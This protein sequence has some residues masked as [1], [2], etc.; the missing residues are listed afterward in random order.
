MPTAAPHLCTAHGCTAIV[1]AGR[2]R[3]EKHT[4]QR[5]A[6]A[7]VSR[8]ARPETAQAARIRSSGQWKQVSATLRAQNPLC[9]V[10]GGLAEHMHHI[11]PLIEAPELAYAPANLAPLC[12]GCHA[13][14]EAMTTAGRREE[15]AVMLK[16]RECRVSLGI[17]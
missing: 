7:D 16:G 17:G 2:P 6:D 1:P 14:V 11:V 8:M 12:R 10:C 13:R 3:C 15:V 9:A 4:A 5:W